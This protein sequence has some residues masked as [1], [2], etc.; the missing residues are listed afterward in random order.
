MKIDYIKIYKRMMKKRETRTDI[1]D[2]VVNLLDIPEP[3]LLLISGY[4]GKE[5]K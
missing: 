3:L 5:K 4:L 2:I 1:I